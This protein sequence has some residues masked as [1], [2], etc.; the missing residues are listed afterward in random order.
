[1]D[2]FRCADPAW[3]VGGEFRRSAVPHREAAIVCVTTPMGHTEPG[4]RKVVQSR[5]QCNDLSSGLT[6]HT[7]L[8]GGNLPDLR[9]TLCL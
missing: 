9:V 5:I 3:P 7:N 8:A 6:G 2:C 4:G 1:M